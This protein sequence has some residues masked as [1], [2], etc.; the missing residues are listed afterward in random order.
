M[1]K[2]KTARR[3]RRSIHRKT[4][5]KTI[6]KSN[7]I[8]YDL[9]NGD[10]WDNYRLGDIINGHFICWDKVCSNNE[11]S[12]K[13]LLNDSCK[14]LEFNI[15]DIDGNKK[16]CIKNTDQWADPK[17]TKLSYIKGIHK[18]YPNSIASRYVTGVGYPKDFEVYD[19]GVLKNIFKKYKYTKPSKSALVIHL[20]LG[21]VLSKKH[22][23]EYTYDIKY[24]KKLLKKIKK[25]N[26]IKQIDIVTGLHK[27]VYV[28][29][30]N[31][32]LNEIINIFTPYYPVRPILTKDPDKDLYY[33]CHS[34]FF[35]NS[36]GGFSRLITDYVKLDKKNKVYED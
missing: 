34:K 17:D 4:I 8:Y 31:D 28:K 21:D 11:I 20:R 22:I 26:K 23:K 18:N 1:K 12:N 14:E 19:F 9:Y 25:N 24:Y 2:Q 16:W 33:M 32:M 36:G 7:Y 6:R 29:K 13:K 5:R 15:D 30:S 35:A 27:N 3:K 10:K